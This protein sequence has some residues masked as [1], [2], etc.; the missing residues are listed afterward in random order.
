MAKP[1]QCLCLFS[2]RS[3]PAICYF[4]N[5]TRLSC[6]MGPGLFRGIVTTAALP[7]RAKHCSSIGNRNNSYHLYRVCVQMS[8]VKYLS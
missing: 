5:T 8:F 6:I 1:A 7:A 2:L 3:F 4:D